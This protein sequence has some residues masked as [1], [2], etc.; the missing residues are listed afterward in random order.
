[1]HCSILQFG[2]YCCKI[3]DCCYIAAGK[4]V[5]RSQLCFYH[6]LL[7]WKKHIKF[8]FLFSNTFFWLKIG[9]KNQHFHPEINGYVFLNKHFWILIWIFQCNIYIYLITW[10]ILP[11]SYSTIFLEQRKAIFQEITSTY[12]K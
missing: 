1:M 3:E 9:T 12:N 5:R 11:H 8:T 4:F 7:I 10:K 6:S 2:G